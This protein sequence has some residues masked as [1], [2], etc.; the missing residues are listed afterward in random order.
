MTLDKLKK[1][2]NPTHED[3][4]EYILEVISKTGAEAYP[5][6]VDLIEML[7]KEKRVISSKIKKLNKLAD[8]VLNEKKHERQK[9]EK[10]DHE[11]FVTLGDISICIQCGATNKKII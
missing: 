6:A 3:I 10:C 4:Q 9:C 5:T 11:T 8:E 2:K 7:L 1:I